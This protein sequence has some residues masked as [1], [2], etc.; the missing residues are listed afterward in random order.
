[1]AFGADDY[2]RQL[3]SLL[4]RGLPWPR[5]ADSVLQRL[6]AGWAD[7]LARVDLRGDALVAEADPRTTLELLE[8]WER[9][10]GLPDACTELGES[11][12]ARRARL[13]AKIV[14]TGGQSP[15]YYI[16]VAAEL[17]YTVTIEEF[18]PWTVDSAV[19]AP[20]S[21]TDW[22]YAWLVRA[23]AETVTWWTCDSGCDEPLASW[24]N[25]LLECVISRLKP[26]H[27]IVLFAYG[28]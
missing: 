28:T 25:T 18:R 12:S 17:G 13:V 9:A 10:Y 22:A 23:P 16:A 11:W 26:A 6:L 1:M 5:S 7:E 27:T 15:A 21:G 8:D 3:A 19:D 4:P 20:I 24:G 14:A 2:R